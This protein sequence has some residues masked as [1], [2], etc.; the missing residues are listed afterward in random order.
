VIRLD[1]IVFGFKE[2][3]LLYDRLS[4]HLEEGQKLGIC[5]PNGSGKTTLL[6]IIM[7]LRKPWEGS[8]HVFNRERIKEEDFF[9]VRKRVGFLFQDPED[10]LFCL[11][12]KEDVAFGPLNLGYSPDEVEEIVEETLCTLELQ[13]LKGRITYK[14]SGGEKRLVSLATVLSMRPEV[15]LL[16][17]PTSGLDEDT[18]GRLIHLLG[19]CVSTLLV[20]SHD[21]DFL[22][23]TTDTIC[24]LQ[25][26][27]LSE[28]ISIPVA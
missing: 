6:H 24:R 25:S 11:T 27:E 28:G 13:H 8:V 14:L 17:E 21:R 22:A 15:L 26:G 2:S 12:V 19:K 3:G 23:S 5:G 16:D 7:G 20:V 18:R 9:E 4:L 1:G 10:Q